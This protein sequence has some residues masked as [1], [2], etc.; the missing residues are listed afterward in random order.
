MDVSELLIKYQDDKNPICDLYGNTLLHFVAKKESL[1]NQLQ[2]CEL[3]INNTEDKNPSNHK[4][5][6]PL[7]SA[8]T[9]GHLGVSRLIIKHVKN[10]N[11]KA[12]NGITPLKIAEMGSYEEICKLIQKA[13]DSVLF[14]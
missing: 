2:I 14:A 6:T 7:H 13:V 9:L 4:G 11:P 1:K 12:K 3:L 5:F 8:A 10:K